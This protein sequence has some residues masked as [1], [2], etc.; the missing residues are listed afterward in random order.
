M[1]P[2]VSVVITTYNQAR[3]IEDTLGTVFKQT[4][5]PLEVI[6]VDDGSTDET[7]N[8]L[9][10][11]G[12]RIRYIRQK[13]Q[14][15]ASSRNTGI[16]HARGE[17]V[18]LLDGDDLW[19]PD[20][21]AVQITAA[22]NFPHSG[23]IVANGVEFDDGKILQPSLLRD[24]E[25]TLG[26]QK[27]QVI[28]VPYYEQALEWNPIWT[29]SQVMIPRAVLQAIGPSDSTFRCGS[30]YDL[31]LRIGQHYD[32]TFIT[33]PLMKW[34]Y[35]ASSASGERDIRALRYRLDHVLALHKQLRTVSEPRR[36]LIKAVLKQRIPMAS[37]SAYYYGRNHNRIISTRMLWRLL[38]ADV[39]LTPF[40]YLMALWVPSM[41]INGTAPAVRRI[42]RLPR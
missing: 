30:D 23:I 33:Q 41:I 4:D 22:K 24:V 25:R 3:Y 31:Y 14:G 18:A 13:N 16:S 2:T 32:M 12:N 20:K 1:G 5:P 42:L 17:Y 19:E 28:T 29:V 39:A 11:F 10:R 9:A 40:L 21:L 15:V 26:L 27:N 34:R 6:V 36:L 35:L 8:R 7:P 38:T 37:E